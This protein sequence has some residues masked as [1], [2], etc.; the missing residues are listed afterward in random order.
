MNVGESE[1]DAVEYELLGVL[2]DAGGFDTSLLVDAGGEVLTRGIA[3]IQAKQ[4]SD[5][6]NRSADDQLRRA[7]AA[8]DLWA[9]AERDLDVAV[10]GGDAGKVSAAKAVVDL[11]SADARAAGAGLSQDRIN[12]RVEHAVTATKAAASAAMGAPGD[13]FKQAALRAWQKVTAAAA[14]PVAPAGAA[15]SD[16]HGSGSFLSRVP[17]W[18]WV[19]GGGVVLLG[20]VLLLRRQG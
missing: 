9:A 2:G 16:G 8:D 15:G 4:A 11:T 18:G 3:A 12:K 7:I 1:M 20:V 10:T 19:A 5:K 6:A 13:A 14:A 17:T